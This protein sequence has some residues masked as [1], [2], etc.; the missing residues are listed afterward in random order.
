MKINK[1]IIILILISIVCCC[2]HNDTVKNKYFFIKNNDTIFYLYSAQ[3]LT[4][5]HKQAMECVLGKIYNKNKTI[6]IDI[7][8]GMDVNVSMNIPSNTTQGIIPLNNREISYY[9]Y[10]NNDMFISFPKRKEIGTKMLLIAK[11]IAKQDSIAIFELV[12]TINW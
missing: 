7:V 2:S 12:K 9:T 1:L 6:N 4:L 5:T 3:I 8:Y 10:L 11:N